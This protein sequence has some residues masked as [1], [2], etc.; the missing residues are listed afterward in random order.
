MDPPI[1]AITVIGLR[2]AVQHIEH[3]SQVIEFITSSLVHE[4]VVEI[5]AVNSEEA[6]EDEAL[7]EAT[8]QVGLVIPGETLEERDHAPIEHLASR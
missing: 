4:A 6:L 5:V 2:L 1:E 3:A 8:G 7:A